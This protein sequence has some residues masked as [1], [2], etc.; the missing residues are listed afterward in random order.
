[1]F[2]LVFIKLMW[3]YW[4]SKYSNVWTFVWLH[5][6]M[7]LGF[8]LVVVGRRYCS[9]LV[10][11]WSTT[12][13]VCTCKFATLNHQLH[14][15]KCQPLAAKTT[16]IHCVFTVSG[17]HSVLVAAV[18]VSLPT[19]CMPVAVGVLQSALTSANGSSYGSFSLE[20]VG[21]LCM[22]LGCKRWS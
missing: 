12:S 7:Y 17:L 20:N 6:S 22:S 14:S 10:R 21:L 11:G 8:C 3:C 13:E 1:M 19:P 2:S 18:E 9:C 15:L 5:L 16:R 4:C